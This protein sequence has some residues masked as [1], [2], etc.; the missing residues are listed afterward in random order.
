MFNKLHEIADEHCRL[1]EH[2]YKYAAIEAVMQYIDD[3]FSDDEVNYYEYTDPTTGDFGILFVSWVED[4][5][6][7]SEVFE[8]RT[9]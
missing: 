9:I 1:F 6:V 7:G 4:G 3:N 8:W 2:Y 5:K